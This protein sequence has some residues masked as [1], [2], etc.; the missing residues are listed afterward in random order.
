MVTFKRGTRLSLEPLIDPVLDS[1][2]SKSF[3]P[4]AAFEGTIGI[5]EQGRFLSIPENRR[6]APPEGIEDA[7]GETKDLGIS[8]DLVFST[9]WKEVSPWSRSIG[10]RFFDCVCVVL[11]LPFLLPI[12]LVIAAAVRLTSRGP[13]LFKQKR[14]GLHGRNFTILKFRTMVHVADRVHHPITTSENQ[15]F[16]P[17]GPFLRRWKLDELPQLANVLLGEMS[18]VGPRPKLPEHVTFD[19]PCRPGIT[20]MAT[21]TFASEETV[22]GYLP[23]DQLDAFYHGVVLPT[24]RKLDADYMTDATF[25]SDIRLLVNTVL[26]RWSTDHLRDF[27]ASS[28]FQWN[29]ELTSARAS[30]SIRAAHC[31]PISSNAN[32]PAEA[33]QVSAF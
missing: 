28:A 33:E 5:K 24:K 26:H 27:I 18:L 1:L 4:Y 6:V 29:I 22:L 2:D 13:V 8:N 32:R 19:L 25:L 20:G 21:I 14:M 16:T 9:G 30:N 12:L 31:M 10:K 3:L 11:A 7:F 17:V 15:H 23:K